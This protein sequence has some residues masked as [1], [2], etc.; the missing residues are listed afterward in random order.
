MTTQITYKKDEVLI[1][2]SDIGEIQYYILE[3]CLRFYPINKSG[4]DI[5]I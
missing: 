4:K 5:T 3:G 2:E 1:N